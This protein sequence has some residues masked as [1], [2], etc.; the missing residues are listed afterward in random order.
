MPYA[1]T[2]FNYSATVFP[3]ALEISSRGT[4]LV[5]LSGELNTVSAPAIYEIDLNTT[6][7]PTTS[8]T[9]SNYTIGTVNNSTIY[10]IGF[11]NN[12]SRQ[13][14]NVGYSHNSTYAVE[15]SD[16]TLYNSYGGVL[17]SPFLRLS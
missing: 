17:E 4:L 3:N 12:K 2:G 13:V 7:Y 14:L 5:G 16:S 9:T 11:I 1:Q 8:F 15:S 6:G 10:K